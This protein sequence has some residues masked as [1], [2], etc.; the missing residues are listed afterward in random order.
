MARTL[1][2]AGIILHLSARSSTSV[3]AYSHM[4]T[5]SYVCASAFA[6][7]SSARA[8][9]CRVESRCTCA[10][11]A[12]FPFVRLGLTS[13]QQVCSRRHSSHV[14]SPPTISKRT[15]ARDK[16]DVTLHTFPW[17]STGEFERIASPALCFLRR[18][19]AK[20]TENN[21][22]ILLKT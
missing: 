17:S 14:A 3:N 16:L 1:C 13:F 18:M 15:C 20:C 12:T 4:C 19:N 5:G 21:N 8:T 7:L 22:V 2:L 10:V 6:F 11:R 9:E